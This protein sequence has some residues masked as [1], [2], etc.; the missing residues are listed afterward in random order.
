MRTIYSTLILLLL[1][2]ACNTGNDKTIE[3]KTDSPVASTNANDSVVFTTENI[4]FERTEV[5]PKPVKSYSE[6][7]KSFETTDEFKVRLYET[8]RTFKYVIKISYQQMEVEDTLRVPNFG[9]EPSVDIIKGDSIRPS[10]IIG[11]FDKEQKF[12]ESKLVYFKGNKM[13]VKV[14]KHYAVYQ[15]D[16]D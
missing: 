10:C 11:F 5:N 14:L 8:K 2:T 13:K 9:I 16:G 12:R 1:V 3:N 15:S 7:I 6:T 4:P